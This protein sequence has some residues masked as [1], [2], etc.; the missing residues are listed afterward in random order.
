MNANKLVI[1]IIDKGGLLG[2]IA[3]NYKRDKNKKNQYLRECSEMCDSKLA[4]DLWGED[5]VTDI[6]E[7]SKHEDFR[8]K[9][10]SPFSV[11]IVKRIKSLRKQ[12][13]IKQEVMAL[14]LN[15]TQSSYSKIEDGFRPL[16]LDQFYIIASLLKISVVELLDITTEKTT[17][18]YSTLQNEK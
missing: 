13:G 3:K 8:Y 11:S 5:L 7:Y 17:L 10:V 6:K 1:R 18:P 12:K 14:S 9:R 16:T 15:L 4:Q 2:A